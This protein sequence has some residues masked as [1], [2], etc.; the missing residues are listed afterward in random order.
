[1]IYH[2]LRIQHFI[3]RPSM[4]QGTVIHSQRFQEKDFT[5]AT[6]EEFVRRF[7]G[8]KPINKVLIANNGIGAVKCMRSVRRW[9]YEM[10]K[11]ER[12]VRFVV[13]VSF[14]SIKYIPNFSSTGCMGGMGSCVR[15]PQA[16]RAASPRWGRVHWTPGEG[17]VGSRRQDRLIHK[18][19]AEYN[20]KKI[21]ISSELFARGC[22][23]TPEEGL[24][25][26]QKIGFPV[27]IKA[28]EGGGGKGIRKVENPDDF[29][30]AFRQVC[31]RWRPLEE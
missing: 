14:Y 26:A 30:S 18:L 20:S 29:N 15:E 31:I 16:P 25:A 11:N 21:K 8:T 2:I 10:F 17:D 22:V 1:M 19:K 6:P 28:S 4:S 13:M 7:Q 5:V 9:S 12:A 27:M 23:T 3:S 24:Q